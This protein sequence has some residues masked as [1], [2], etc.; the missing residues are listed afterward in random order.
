MK[1]SKVILVGAGP[2]DKELITLKGIK[3]IK[4]A[5]IIFYDALVNPELLEF[6]RKNT[7]LIYVGKRRNEKRFSQDEIHEL[8]ASAA[9]KYDVIV[10]LKGGDPFV[11]G[12]GSEEL[13]YLENKGIQT[14]II[15]G[16][17]SALAV[18]ATQGIPLTKRGLNESFYVITGT[19]SDGS[20][21]KDLKYGAMSNA[22]LVI[23]MGLKN[24][25]PIIEETLKYRDESTPFAIIQNGTR[26][27]ESII[28]IQVIYKVKILSTGELEKLKARIVVRGDIQQRYGVLSKIHTWI[29]TSGF[30]ILQ[31]VLAEV[32]KRGNRVRQLDFIAAFCQGKMQGR[33]FIQFP[34]ICKDLFPNCRE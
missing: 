32:A 30:K 12:R 14:E 7:E 22:T 5:D 26:E 24:I 28:P 8:L 3:A 19:T 33:L 11:F 31:C 13:N 15:P 27:G 25:E 2:G 23:L 34:S 6:A 17:S 4:A 9:Y 29:A 21:S 10:R 20:V 16:I 18:P 1:N